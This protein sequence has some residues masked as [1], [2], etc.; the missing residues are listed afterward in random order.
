MYTLKNL[1]LKQFTGKDIAGKKP[2]WTLL[3]S[4]GDMMTVHAEFLSF[5]PVDPVKHEIIYW[6]NT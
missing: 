2:P 5:D 3:P 1:K 6:N 4:S